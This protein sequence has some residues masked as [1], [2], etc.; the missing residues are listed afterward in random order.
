VK[1]TRSLGAIVF[2]LTLLGAQ[3]FAGNEGRGTESEKIYRDI[4]LANPKLAKEYEETIVQIQ[5]LMQDNSFKEDFAVY[6]QQVPDRLVKDPYLNSMLIKMKKMALAYENSINGNPLD[7]PYDFSRTESHLESAALVKEALATNYKDQATACVDE[8]NIPREAVTAPEP[9]SNTCLYSKGLALLYVVSQMTS[10]DL[11]MDKRPP[12]SVESFLFGHLTHELARK[13]S[14]DEDDRVPRLISTFADSQFLVFDQECFIHKPFCATGTIAEKPKLIYGDVFS[15]DPQL[16]QEVRVEVTMP[17][18]KGQAAWWKQC[19]KN[20]F[21][22]VNN[23]VVWEG[24]DLPMTTGVPLEKSLVE[25]EFAMTVNLHTY[26]MPSAVSGGHHLEDTKVIQIDSGHD[27]R[28][29]IAQYEE[30]VRKRYYPHDDEPG[31]ASHEVK[32]YDA[33]HSLIT[34]QIREFYPRNKGLEFFY[35]PIYLYMVTRSPVQVRP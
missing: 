2:L 29:S 17:K 7:I 23:F 20:N 28:I 21:Y 25:G 8:D 6:I 1:L 12:E 19:L 3:A 9:R 5:K 11:P 27:R 34:K 35:P 31:C 10:K 33:S 16:A 18:P 30:E 26:I 14:L 13:Y 24:Y 32:F 4:V 22:V 15:W